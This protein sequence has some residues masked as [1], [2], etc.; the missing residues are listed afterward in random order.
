MALSS[1]L[2]GQDLNLRPSGYEPDEL[3]DCSTPQVN[4][5]KTKGQLQATIALFT[6]CVVCFR[7]YF[8]LL[9]LFCLSLGG[10]R[11]CVPVVLYV[12]ASNIINAAAHVLLCS[13]IC[14]ELFQ[15]DSAVHNSVWGRC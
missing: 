15:L 6:G 12:Q 1:L 5:T 4:T 10:H 7:I 3:P 11:L 9:V 8:D 2:R 13:L 14:E